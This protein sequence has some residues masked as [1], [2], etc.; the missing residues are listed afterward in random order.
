M[1]YSEGTS[2]KIYI[3]D[4]IKSDICISQRDGELVFKRVYAAFQN[5]ERVVLSFAGIRFII[6]A[7][8]N[9]ALGMLYKYFDSSYLNSNLSVVE[10]SN[11]QRNMV[12]EVLKNAKEYWLDTNKIK[13]S[14]AES[15]D[16]N[17]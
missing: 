4:V 9:P 7:F 17:T 2:V 6:S 5:D 11:D 13:E 12:R 1:T 14:L 8:L 10:I 15:I 16:E 3:R